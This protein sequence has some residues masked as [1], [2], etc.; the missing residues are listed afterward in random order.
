MPWTHTNLH[1]CP[2]LSDLMG[3]PEPCLEQPWF[4]GFPDVGWWD[5]AGVRSC[6]SRWDIVQVVPK[7]TFNFKTKNPLQAARTVHAWLG[8]EVAARSWEASGGRAPS[9]APSAGHCQ[10]PPTQGKRW[11]WGSK[12]K[13]DLEGMVLRFY[14]IEMGKS[15]IWKQ[16]KWWMYELALW[17]QIIKPPSSK[18]NQGKITKCSYEGTVTIDEKSK[19]SCNQMLMKFKMLMKLDFSGKI[20]I[21][22]I[23]IWRHFKSIATEQLEKII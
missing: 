18:Y 12:D 2:R 20:E 11:E 13:R 7:S 10:L 14:S 17:K 21:V 16:K 5:G 1:K 4:L 6:R 15:F 19:S 8:W 3:S 22:Q 23:E 9:W